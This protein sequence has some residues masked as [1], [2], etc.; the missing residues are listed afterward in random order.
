[1]N[2]TMG[3]MR[4]FKTAQFTV[5]CTAEE[6]DSLD[7]SWDDDGSVAKGLDRG[8]LIAFC[9]TVKVYWK[10]REVGSDYL[11]GCIYKSFDDFMDHRACG[12]QNR[13]F[14]KQGVEGRC[15]SYFK[16]MIHEAIDEARKTLK[17][18][19]QALTDLH[20]R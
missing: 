1:M 16:D 15:G 6:E 2:S 18:D 20:V 4:T 13:E 19:R 7:L 10:G 8:T 14:E 3:T 9:A 11:G 12:K 5:V 17:N